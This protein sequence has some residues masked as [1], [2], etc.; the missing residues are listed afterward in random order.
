VLFESDMRLKATCRVIA[1]K[2]WTPYDLDLK[3]KTTTD[4]WT[5]CRSADGQ[6]DPKKK[7]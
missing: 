7:V 5:C 2:R 3:V 1:G 6:H 4:F